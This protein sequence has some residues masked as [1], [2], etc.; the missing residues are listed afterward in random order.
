MWT[1]ASIIAILAAGVVLGCAPRPASIADPS[2]GVNAH[3]AGA[4]AP[5]ASTAAA[6]SES[7]GVRVTDAGTAPTADEGERI[8]APV[9]P[10]H[11]VEPPARKTAAP[12]DGHW[13]PFVVA[14]SGMPP[15]MFRTV[16]HPHPE[17]KW[18]TVTVVAIDS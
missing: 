18:I 15:V 5:S 12:G 14:S 16:V 13:T 17:S 7:A 6:P 8:Q 11:D 4:A 3:F 10:P 9:F 2:A 1:S